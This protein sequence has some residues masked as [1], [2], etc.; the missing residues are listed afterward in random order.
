MARQFA[1]SARGVVVRAESHRHCYQRA[2]ANGQFPSNRA[3]LV[4]MA[5]AKGNVVMFA[6][7][8]FWRWQTQGTYSLGFNAIMIWTRVKRRKSRPQPRPTAVKDNREGREGHP[9]KDTT[10]LLGSPKVDSCSP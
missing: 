3:A 7:R 9:T 1:R 10:T 5:L 8:P 4:D 6:I 2:L